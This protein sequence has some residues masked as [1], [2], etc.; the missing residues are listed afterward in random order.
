VIKGWDEGLQLMAKGGKAILIIPSS[1]AYNDQE[2]GS[3]P[4]YSTL[5]FDLEILDVK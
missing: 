3:I 4:P 2:M 5:V 1:I